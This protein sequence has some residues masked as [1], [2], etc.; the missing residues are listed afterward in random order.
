MEKLSGVFRR[1]KREF[2]R[3]REPTL[4]CDEGVYRGCAVLTLQKR[5]WRNNG[6]RRA[7]D[8][9][10]IFF[11]VWVGAND[12]KRKRA[13]YNIHAL[14]L[15]QLAG[16]R[17]TSRDFAKDFRAEFARVERA[18]PNVSVDYGPQTLM[19]GWIE[20]DAKRFAGDVLALLHRFDGVSRI[21]DQLLARRVAAEDS[22]H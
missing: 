21:I 19:R 4:T 2:E 1:A 10:G 9:T 15:R 13:N 12:A 7:P 17:I 5:C 20:I 6:M 16:Y 11:S 8:D 18:W 14:K 3:G 22:C